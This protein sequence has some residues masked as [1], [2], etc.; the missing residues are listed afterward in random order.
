MFRKYDVRG[1][2]GSEITPEKFVRLGAAL[3]LSGKELALGRDYRVHND[4]LGKALLTGYSGTVLDVGVCPTP[5][6][7]FAAEKQGAMLTASHNPPEYAGLKLCIERH[8]ATV[9]EMFSLSEDYDSAVVAP[10]TPCVEDA[11]GLI[12]DYCG[13]LPAFE[14]GLYDLGGGAACALPQKIFPQTLF[15]KPD[16]WF[17]HHSPLPE[18]ATLGALKEATLK[19]GK[20]GF[21]FDGDGDRMMAVDGGKVVDGGIVTA[22][23]AQKK[24]KASERVVVNIDFRQ[25]VKEFI[26]ESGFK[27]TICAVGMNSVYEAAVHTRAKFG[28]ERNGHYLFMDHLPASDGFYPAALLSSEKP[29]VIASFA[30]QFTNEFIT[31]TRRT[32]ADLAG[33]AEACVDDGAAVETID[34]VW[35]DYGDYVLLIRA[36]NTEPLI[37]IN[38]EARTRELALAGI[39]KADELIEACK[40]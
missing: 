16:P 38:S 15:S 23:L 31:Q 24:L 25:D 2:Y 29:G 14:D 12:Q 5:V 11:S 17:G 1:V 34:G 32:S 21:A 18:D 13:S 20:V 40:K 8:E 33:I 37:R 28:A 27:L 4:A 30:E 22:F 6:L 7:A 35:A 3:G 19:R 10:T 39:K 36:S 9:T 26:E